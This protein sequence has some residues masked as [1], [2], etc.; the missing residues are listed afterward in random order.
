LDLSK[1]AKENFCDLIQDKTSINSIIDILDNYVQIKNATLYY[2]NRGE[3]GSVKCSEIRIGIVD[4]N[5]RIFED[6]IVFPIDDEMSFIDIICN[7]EE[8]DDKAIEFY[9]NRKEEIDQRFLLFV[10][11]RNILEVHVGKLN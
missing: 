4:S 11:N 8:L 6:F 9:A 1:I 10:E 3:L 2:P 7:F 5:I